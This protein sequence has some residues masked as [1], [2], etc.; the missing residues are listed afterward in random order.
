[1]SRN[2]TT[3]HSVDNIGHVIDHTYFILFW[4]NP[5]LNVV[6]F[7]VRF[8]RLYE[9]AENK[10]VT[11]IDVNTMDWGVNGKTLKWRQILFTWEEEVRE[12]AELLN[13]VFS[14]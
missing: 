5:W 1:M 14:Y 6:S 4:K 11:I 10:L 9:L 12:W 8:N 2:K 7:F 3:I 13:S